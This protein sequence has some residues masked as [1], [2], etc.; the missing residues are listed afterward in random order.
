MRGV[1]PAASGTTCPVTASAFPATP[2]I[3]GGYGPDRGGH[4]PDRDFFLKQALDSRELTL[5]TFTHQGIGDTVGFGA[6]SSANAVYIILSIMRHVIVDDQVDR[7]DI[8]PPT[9]DIGGYQ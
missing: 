4:L 3:I 9:Q 5:F 1:T 8:D 7:I 6:C 2:G